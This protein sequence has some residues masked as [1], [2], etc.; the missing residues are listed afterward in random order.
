MKNNDSL[1][2][3]KNIREDIDIKLS[4]S[5]FIYIHMCINIY[6]YVNVCVY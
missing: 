4:L 2:K 5:R 3:Y 1:V 6:I